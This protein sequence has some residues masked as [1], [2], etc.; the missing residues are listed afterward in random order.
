MTN[1]DEDVEKR[2]HL[3]TAGGKVKWYSYRGKQYGVGVPVM[4][5]W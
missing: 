1:V 3:Y 2:E 4:T 5:Q